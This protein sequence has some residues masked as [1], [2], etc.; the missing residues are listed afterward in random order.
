VGV[1]VIQNSKVVHS[2]SVGVKG[3]ATLLLAK[4]VEMDKV[5]WDYPDMESGAAF[6]LA[7]QEYIFEL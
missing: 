5:N 7:M 3:M 6:D 4:L 2:G 1:G